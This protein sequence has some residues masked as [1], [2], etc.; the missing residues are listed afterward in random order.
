VPAANAQLGQ[1]VA[2]ARRSL[3]SLPDD[4]LQ[5][6]EAGQRTWFTLNRLA[7]PRPGARQSKATVAPARHALGVRLPTL[8]AYLAIAPREKVSG[9]GAALTRHATGGCL[10]LVSPAVTAQRRGSGCRR[11]SACT[12]LD[13]GRPR[14]VM[15]PRRQYR[16]V[17]SDLTQPVVLDKDVAELPSRVRLVAG[18]HRRAGVDDVFK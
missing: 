17:A 11:V 9:A 2:L 18:R 7:G 12:E 14:V 5:D 8:C 3:T 6:D 15:G 10:I 4:V 13:S 1:D 16:D